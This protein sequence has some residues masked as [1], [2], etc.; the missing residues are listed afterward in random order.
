MRIKGNFLKDYVQTVNQTPELDWNK[1]LTESDWQIV[2]SII[3]PSQWYPAELMG[4]IG[5]GLFV[6]RTKNN[7]SLVRLHGR[8]RLDTAFDEETKKFLTKADP[9]AAI[10]AYVMIARRYIDEVSIKLEKSGPGFAI[11]CWDPV[12]E[13]PSWDLFREIQAGTMEKLIELNGG[14]NPQTKFVSEIRNGR[15]AGIIHL[16]WQGHSP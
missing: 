12:D 8:S 6:M 7:Y 11:V 3:I 10:Q 4:R 1:F 13:T 16:T 5:R 9:V 2:R 14:K 15:E